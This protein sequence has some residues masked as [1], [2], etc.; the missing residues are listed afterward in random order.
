MFIWFFHHYK[1]RLR[2]NSNFDYNYFNKIRLM[3]G[4]KTKK[5]ENKKELETYA[6]YISDYID[7]FE[8]KMI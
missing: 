4:N 7:G 2:K 5:K 3:K 8:I 6:S 1:L